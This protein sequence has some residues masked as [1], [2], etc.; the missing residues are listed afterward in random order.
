MSEKKDYFDY[1]ESVLGVG[2]VL[3]DAA[4]KSDSITEKNSIAV[5]FCVEHLS[6]YS[7]TEKE[8]LKKMITAVGLVP[9]SFRIVDIS[10]EST[11]EGEFRVYFCDNPD[12]FSA[13]TFPSVVTF[14]PKVLLRVPQFKRHAW[15]ELQK[16]MA[17]FKTAGK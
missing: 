11:I 12:G 13:G 7:D 16:V 2:S 4:V 5:I 9:E 17:H 10:E 15:D 6:T 14:S 8:L 1:V 3:I